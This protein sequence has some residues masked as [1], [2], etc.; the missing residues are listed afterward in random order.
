MKIELIENDLNH[1][2]HLFVHLEKLK[3]ALPELLRLA[4]IGLEAEMLG[5]EM[6]L[7]LDD[8]EVH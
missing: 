2:N 3:E 6:E 4:R 5:A 8:P 1:V 7:N